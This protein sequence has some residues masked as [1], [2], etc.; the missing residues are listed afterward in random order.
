MPVIGRSCLFPLIMYFKPA[1]ACF[2]VM[3]IYSCHGHSCFFP[4]AVL[5][6]ST[7]PTVCCGSKAATCSSHQLPITSPLRKLPFP[8][9]SCFSRSCVY[10]SKTLCNFVASC[11]FLSLSHAPDCRAPLPLPILLQLTPVCLCRPAIAMSFRLF[12]PMLTPCTVTTPTSS[13]AYRFRFPSAFSS[14]FCALR[15]QIA[16]EKQPQGSH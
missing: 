10:I 16:L 6:P 8:S 4:P 7:C 3:L 1:H 13:F 5:S 11:D 2:L 9:R 15:Y 12:S 14:Y